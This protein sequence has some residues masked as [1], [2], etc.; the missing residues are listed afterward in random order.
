MTCP[1]KTG[2]DSELGYIVGPGLNAVV[3]SQEENVLYLSPSKR[4][5]VEIRPRGDGNMGPK[6]KPGKGVS[7]GKGALWWP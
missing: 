3:L 7:P 2:P 1:P 6:I 4:E 5:T